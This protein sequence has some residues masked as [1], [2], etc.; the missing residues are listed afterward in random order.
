MVGAGVLS[1]SCPSGVTLSLSKGARTT[2]LQT[3][4]RGVVFDRLR[5]TPWWAVALFQSS[6]A[7]SKVL[8]ALSQ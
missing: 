1:A 3:H 8:T 4:V 6:L 5:L 2:A 7:L